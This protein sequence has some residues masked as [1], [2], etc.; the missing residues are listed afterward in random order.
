MR[1]EPRRR[2]AAESPAARK[3]RPTIGST[4]VNGAR[5]FPENGT[6]KLPNLADGDQPSA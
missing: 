2:E 4:G 5:N 6:A 1:I 3:D